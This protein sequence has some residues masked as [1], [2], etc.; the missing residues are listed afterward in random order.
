[1]KWL[2][3]FTKGRCPLSFLKQRFSQYNT[4]GKHNDF[5]YGFGWVKK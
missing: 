2:K 5:Y 3:F 1:M 4:F